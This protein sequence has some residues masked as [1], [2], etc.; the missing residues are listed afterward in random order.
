[1]IRIDPKRAA[2]QILA[3]FR[4]KRGNAT[5]VAHAFGVDRRTLNRW[6]QALRRAGVDLSGDV[7]TVREAA[8][9]RD[10]RLAGEVNPG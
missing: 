5:H 7:E 6:L 4:R 8:R 9:A 2:R 3:M 1:M 10:D